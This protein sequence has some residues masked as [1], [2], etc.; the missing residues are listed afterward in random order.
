MMKK[1]KFILLLLVVA[2]LSGCGEHTCPRI[3]EYGFTMFAGDNIC[4]DIPQAKLGLKGYEIIESES[5]VDVIFHYDKK[6]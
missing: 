2:V 6:D 4:I 1:V 3:E 5:G